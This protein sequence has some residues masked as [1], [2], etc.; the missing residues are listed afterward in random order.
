MTDFA[1]S[2]AVAPGEVVA[3]VGGGSLMSA[4]LRL[5]G[6]LREAG[7]TVV[8]TSTV[9]MPAPN[10]SAS[11]YFMVE[12]DQDSLTARLPQLLQEHGHV[13]LAAERVRDDKIRGVDPGWVPDMVAL[14]GVG[15][16]VVESDGARHRPLKAP[17]E[18]EPVLPLLVDVLLVCAG[19]DVLGKPLDEENV[20]RPELVSG[21]T[22]LHPGEP[23]TTRAV[24]EVLTSPHGGLK[25]LPNMARV[26]FVLTGWRDTN[27][28]EAREI[29]QLALERAPQAR[30]AILLGPGHSGAVEAITAPGS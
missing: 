27:D 25:N 12:P 14:P 2:V 20:H 15:N 22:G 8:S 17:K 11:F 30:G 18:D 26:W 13:R 16:V 19:L 9:Y 10:P 3:L 29:A 7:R 24:A 1:E 6:E 28:A 5:A 23:V 21:I 4:A